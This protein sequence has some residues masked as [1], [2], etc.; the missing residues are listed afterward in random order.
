MADRLALSKTDP[1]IMTRQLGSHSDPRERV[2]GDARAMLLSA[3]DTEASLLNVARLTVPELADGCVIH[4]QDHD[5]TMRLLAALHAEKDCEA[6]LRTLHRREADGVASEEGPWNVLRSGEPELLVDAGTHYLARSRDV[7]ERQLLERVELGSSLSAPMIFHQRLLGAIT[8]FTTRYG[9]RLTERDLALVQEVAHCAAG[10][11][12]HAQL[13]RQSERRS[14]VNDEL[15][16][17]YAHNLRNPLGSARIWLELLRSEKL[18]AGGVRA[19]TMVDRSIRHLADLVS[20]MLDVSQVVTGRISL[21]KQATD[22]PDLLARVSKAAE[23]VAR[24]KRV[25]LEVEIDRSIEWLWADP[26]RLRQAV[27]NLLSNAIKFTPPGGSVSIRLE[28]R[29]SRARIEVR[30]TG[31]GIPPESLKTVLDGFR[32]PGSTHHGLGL[33]IARRVTELH[34][35]RIIAESEGQGKGCVFTLDLPMDAAPTDAAYRLR[36]PR[37]T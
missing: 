22:L 13:F 28:R 3:T 8:L 10:A 2:L 21:D 15:L 12:A 19:V 34:E 37:G 7:G 31:I 17:A 9:R 32:D 20:Q 1:S 14:R 35:G 5:G 16:A 30:D 29:G 23:P 25:Q 6:A 11:V 24:E 33:A 27:E 36:H 18:G 26:Q 4:A